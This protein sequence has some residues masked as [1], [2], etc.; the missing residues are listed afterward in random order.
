MENSTEKHNRPVRLL[1]LLL[2]LLLLL[3]LGG[4]ACP[5]YNILGLPCPGCGMTRALGAA[6]AGDLAL[7][8]QLHPLFW[9]P[10]VLLPGSFLLPLVFKN[11]RQRTFFWLAIGLAFLLVYSSRLILYFPGPEPMDFNQKALLPQVWRFLAAARR[12]NSGS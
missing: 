2:L 10:P 3:F 6:L 8:W 5:V 7:A 1:P 12:A 9:L 11:R 4:P